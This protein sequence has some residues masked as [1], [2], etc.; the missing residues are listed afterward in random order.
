MP[1]SNTFFP[2]F[3]A[4]KFKYQ[5]MC[6][7]KE[8]S[9]SWEKDAKKASTAFLTWR[10]NRLVSSC[11]V[12][13]LLPTWHQKLWLT[14]TTVFG[15][16]NRNKNALFPIWPFF[17]AAVNW[18]KRAAGRRRTLFCAF[19]ILF[20]TR[21]KTCVQKK[22]DSLFQLSFF[23]FLLSEWYSFATSPKLNHN[24]PNHLLRKLC[25]NDIKMT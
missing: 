16:V 20:G 18:N 14:V 1:N 3:P 12:F 24:W 10:T 7:S 21:H 19:V 6:H 4:R 17:A 25:Q 13:F 2:G 8:A 5:E 23:L 22:K 15:Y 9:S 11:K